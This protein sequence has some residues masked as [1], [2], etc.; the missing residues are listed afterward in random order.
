MRSSSLAG[1]ALVLAVCAVALRAQAPAASVAAQN[2]EVASVKPSN[3]NPTGP[4]GAT[5]IVLPALGR[6]TAQNVTLRLL[7]MTAYNR[8]P[9]EIIGGP[10][11]WNQNKYDIT[12]KA[13]DGSAKLD[14]MRLMLR[15][16]LAD[17]FKLKAHT[18]TRDV[19]TYALVLAR[20]VGKLGPKM[21]VSTDNCPDYKE[22]QQKM[23]EAIAKGGVSAL[24]GMLGKPGENKPCSVTQIPP[25]PDNL[26]LGFKA[27]G[28]SLELL[29][30]LL[31][32]LSGRPVVNKTGLTGPYDFELTISLQTLAAIYQ[33]LGVTLPLP[34]NL[35][36]GPALMTTVQ[37]D[38]GL[39]LDSQRGPSE[40]LVVDGAEMPTPD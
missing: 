32:Q 34:P 6:L 23:L 26:A 7:V 11:W 21:K 35:P 39:K 38:L 20:G 28:Q 12:A 8:Q 27:T 33:E 16:L 22:Q 1:V 37:E 13:A 31:T 24:Q 29:V 4:L 10:P 3:P 18:E 36:E 30:T 40:V 17:R 2:F 15:G 19:P 14:D 25:T 9:F 5:P